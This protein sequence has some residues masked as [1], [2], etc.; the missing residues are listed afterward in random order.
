MLT[1]DRYEV[2]AYLWNGS[3][4][5]FDLF[6]YGSC[7][8]QGV[9][10]MNGFDR[11]WITR[12]KGVDSER[13]WNIFTGGLVKKKPRSYNQTFSIFPSN[14]Y[15][16][17]ARWTIFLIYIHTITCVSFHLSRYPF[18][19]TPLKISLMHSPISI[20]TS[21][22]EI[23]ITLP[24]EIFK[25]PR[26]DVIEI[27]ASSLEINRLIDYPRSKVSTKTVTTKF[28]CRISVVRSHANDRAALDA[29][30]C[31]TEFDFHWST[32][33]VD[34]IPRKTVTATPRKIDFWL[35]SNNRPPFT[36]R[37]GRVGF[38]L[39]D[40]KQNLYAAPVWFTFLWGI[41]FSGGTKDY[42]ICPHRFFVEQF[43][44]IFI[45]SFSI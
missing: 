9:F 21:L 16:V 14:L 38:R 5:L 32:R 31:K 12:I 6:H 28:R 7:L 11:L 13:A 29:A 37:V 2:V 44:R 39:L 22:I 27:E 30:W 3:C 25:L 35:E 15:T 1:N 43:L 8:L 26:F 36:L 40:R 17:I 18:Y 42:I 34:S 24:L 45:S 4:Q 20:Y 10:K 41:L 33:S 19:F 23:S